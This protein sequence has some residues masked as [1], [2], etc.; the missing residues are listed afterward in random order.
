MNFNGMWAEPGSDP[1][2]TLVPG[3]GEKAVLAEY[4][5]RYR[6]TFE[7]KCEGLSDE[8]LATRSVPPSTMSLL[9]LVRHLARVEHSWTRRVFEGHSELPRLYRTEADP[10]LDFNQAVADSG[11]IAEAWDTWREEVDHSRA[12]YADLDLDNVLDVHGQ[13]VEVRDIVVHLVEEY[14]RH[15]GHADLLRECIDGRTGQ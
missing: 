12:V 15:V 6:M 10:D 5:D 8:Q 13:Q 14:A 4:L 7:L 9:G 2:A 3:K 1:R 11:V